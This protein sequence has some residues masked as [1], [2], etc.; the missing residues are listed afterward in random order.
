VKGIGIRNEEKE[1]ERK[2]EIVKMGELM[3]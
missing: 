1:E 3:K 2:E